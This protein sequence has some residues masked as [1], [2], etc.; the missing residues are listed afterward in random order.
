MM[1]AMKHRD[2]VLQGKAFLI[3]LDLKWPWQKLYFV[4]GSIEDHQKGFTMPELEE[5]V[6]KKA[7]RIQRLL[8]YIRGNDTFND[9]TVPYALYD[10]E[11]RFMYYRNIKS[12]QEYE[13]R[14]MPRI[15]RQIR[16]FYDK[17]DNCRHILKTPW[18]KRKAN[19][20]RKV[21]QARK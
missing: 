7:P 8:N 3:D 12:A 1:K 13:K 5:I 17:R 2:M 15:D 4:F 10:R 21:V 20:R 18:S 14:V 11:D 19:I 9:D 6:G 16:G